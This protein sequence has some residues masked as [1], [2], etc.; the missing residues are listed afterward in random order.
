MNEKILSILEEFKSPLDQVIVQ[1]FISKPD[2]SGVI[3]TRNI[4]NNSPYYFINID[5]SGRTD[6]ITSGKADPSMKTL[7]FF[8]DFDQYKIEKK[9]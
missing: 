8:R 3:F 7:V 5:N 1:E 4:N 6:L 9:I 2:L